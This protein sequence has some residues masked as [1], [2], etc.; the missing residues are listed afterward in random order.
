[1]YP[2]RKTRLNKQNTPWYLSVLTN[3][4]NYNCWWHRFSIWNTKWE[5]T[6]MDACIFRWPHCHRERRATSMYLCLLLNVHLWYDD[7]YYILNVPR[8]DEELHSLF[9]D[10]F[11]SLNT[12]PSGYVNALVMDSRG[13]AS[14]SRG[15]LLKW[16][17]SL[18][19]TEFVHRALYM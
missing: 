13:V 14:S 2:K 11:E 17:P 5:P 1:M 19:A 15:L 4:R 8:F 12:F 18:M 9:N 3:K 7:E 16:V 10:R 6:H